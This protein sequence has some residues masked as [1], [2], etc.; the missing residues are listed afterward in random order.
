MDL[1]AEVSFAQGITAEPVTGETIRQARSSLQTWVEAD[2]RLRL[3][4]LTRTW[5]FRGAFG[6]TTSKRAT[7][8]FSAAERL[9]VA[10]LSAAWEA[11]HYDAQARPRAELESGAG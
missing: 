7:A 6:R 1:A 10:A 3:V 11:A 4:T 8:A 5:L 2:D 9:D